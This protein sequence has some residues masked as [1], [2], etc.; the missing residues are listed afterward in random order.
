MPLDKTY[1]RGNRKIVKCLRDA[2]S[3]FTDAVETIVLEDGLEKLEDIAEKMSEASISTAFSGVGCPEVASN[4]MWQAI[5]HKLNRNI[6]KPRFLSMIEWDHE[7]QQELLILGQDHDACVYGDICDFFKP[8][9]LP[10]INMLKK[11]PEMALQ[12]LGDVVARGKAVTRFAPCLRHGRRCGLKVAKRHVAGT[13]CTAFSSQGLQLGEDVTVCDGDDV[14]IFVPLVLHRL[15]R[16]GPH[17]VRLPKRTRKEVDQM[18]ASRE[19]PF[20]DQPIV[21][22]RLEVPPSLRNEL[23]GVLLHA[24]LQGWRDQGRSHHGALLG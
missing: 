21:A 17:G 11:S 5:K 22:F 16:H 7:A 14:T 8:E 6:A 24:P 3:F 10:T 9:L 4:M 15:L 18:Q 13:C 20:G 23:A 1:E 2:L 19:D 12:V